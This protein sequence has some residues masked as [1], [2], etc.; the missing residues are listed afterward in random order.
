MK[1]LL[2]H[3][4]R[5][6]FNLL[7][8]IE[9]QNIIFQLNNFISYVTTK[10]QHFVFSK[11]QRDEYLVVI[12]INHGLVSYNLKPVKKHFYFQFIIKRK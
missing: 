6:K 2:E 7:F 1:I 5:K 8:Y 3:Y 9:H 11:V 4:F 10:E 12:Q